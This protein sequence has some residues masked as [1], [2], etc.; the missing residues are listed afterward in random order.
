MLLDS[1][2]NIAATYDYDAFGNV[3]SVSNVNPLTSQNPYQFHSEYRDSSTGLV[4]LRAR[5]YEPREGRFLCKDEFEG[6]QENPTS[7]NKYLGFSNNPVN[8]IDPSG[9]FSVMEA[10]ISIGAMAIMAT[11]PSNIYASGD[12]KEDKIKAIILA[13]VMASAKTGIDIDILGSLGWSESPSYALGYWDRN[14]GPANGIMQLIEDKYAGI[15]DM[16]NIRIGALILK[17]KHSDAL[18]FQD[19]GYFTVRDKKTDEKVK[20]ELTPDEQANDWLLAVRLYKG[21]IGNASVLAKDHWYDQC[22]LTWPDPIGK[23]ENSSKTLS[24]LWKK[25][26]TFTILIPQ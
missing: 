26:D 14:K 13:F 4:Y 9:N 10:G 3:L 6:T 21:A 1:I 2:G 11:L 16:E 12:S 23:Y 24:N 20:Y 8:L 17:D 18:R 5:W 19:R 7:L 25:R 15:S 22:Y